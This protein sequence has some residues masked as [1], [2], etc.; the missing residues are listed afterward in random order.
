MKRYSRTHRYSPLTHGLG[1]LLVAF[2]C[3]AALF[4]C[5]GGDTINQVPTPTV[6]SLNVDV[7]PASAIVVVTGPASFTQTFTG[8]KLLTDLA[9]GQYTAKA[10]A[11]GFGE[12]TKSIN[13][14]AGGRSSISL[15]L[16]ATVG[17][18]NVNV[19]PAS[20]TVVVTGPA[21]FTQQTF[22]G[23]KFLANLAP[24]QYTAK[25]TAPGFVDATSS[26]N[27]VVGETSSISLVLQA[28]PILSEAPR[29]V[30]RDGQANL[31]PLDSSGLQSGQFVFYAWLEDKPLGILPA[32]LTSTTVSDPGKPLVAEQTESAPSFTQNLA[33]AWIGFK[34]AAGVVR[35]VI[36]ADVRWEIDQWWSGR[37]NSMQFG[38]SDDNRIALGYGVYDDQAD[39]RTNNSRL[40]GERFPLIASEY[41]LYNQTGVGTP[42]VDG[43][44]WVT[45]FS[46]DAKAAGRIVAVAT[47]NGE[48]IGKQILY[49]NFAPA[50]KLEITKT[51]NPAVVNLVGG[52][53][54]ATWTVTVKNVALVT[55]RPSIS[56]T[57]WHRAQ[58]RATH[59]A[60]FRQA[61]RRSATASLTPSRSLRAPR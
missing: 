16:N 42:F 4:G 20:A 35:P 28:T 60:R 51:A 37:V 55:P 34:D 23:N 33:G 2:V 32:K 40:E 52:T 49:K 6:G 48:E 3:A 25:A 58:G 56:T 59:P 31:I 54:T 11:T 29:A 47:I 30:Y 12:V 7:T 53:G 36:G 18:L 5:G 38:T 14:T 9:P 61:V 8:D 50:P 26:I 46:P 13:V 15:D 17:S 10:T 19:N 45:L 43:F 1:V 41:P 24:G 22:T 57:S 39:T 21:G 44:T 27:V